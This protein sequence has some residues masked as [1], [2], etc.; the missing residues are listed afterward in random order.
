MISCFDVRQESDQLDDFEFE[1]FVELRKWR[2]LKARELGIETY[3]I[4]QNKTMCELIRRKRNDANWANC[5]V[6]TGNEVG[7]NDDKSIVAVEVEWDEMSAKD[8]LECW[9]IGPS[10]VKE[11]G[12]AW[13]ALAVLNKPNML[14]LLDNSRKITEQ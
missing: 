12:F 6:V 7:E 8:L 10:K 3:K 11:G 5:K 14:E 13:Q 1:V 9:G 4:F 2:L